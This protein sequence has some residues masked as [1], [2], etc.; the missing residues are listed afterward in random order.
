LTPALAG[1]VDVYEDLRVGELDE[2]KVGD[3]AAPVSRGAST[4]FA[5][6]T[7][8]RFVA[9][10]GALSGTGL[11]EALQQLVSDGARTVTVTGHSLG[12]CVST[13]VGLHLQDV[14]AGVTVQ[15]VTFAAPTAGLQGFA[16]MFDGAFGGATGANSAYRVVNAWDVVPHAWATLG[17][18]GGWYP[19][20]GPAQCL[21]VTGTLLVLILLPGSNSYVQPSVNV[22]TLNDAQYGSPGSLWDANYEAPTVEGF[23]GQALFQHS[24]VHAYMPLLGVSLPLVTPEEAAAGAVSLIE[25]GFVHTFAPETR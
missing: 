8:A 4:A 20:P 3:Q 7:G 13:M 24:V 6:V 9:A 23:K 1:V 22:V 21:D 12:G 25:P 10:D 19:S 18:L 2:F 15:V 5:G 17:D 16:D 14:L 11:V